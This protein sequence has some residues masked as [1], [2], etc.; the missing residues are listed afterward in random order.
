MKDL[1]IGSGAR[2]GR[3]NVRGHRDLR[4][5][6][7]AEREAPGFAGFRTSCEPLM[8]TGDGVAS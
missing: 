5:L 7:G 6:R 3:K 1:T 2:R 4:N 8:G